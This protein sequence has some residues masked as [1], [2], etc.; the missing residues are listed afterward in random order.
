MVVMAR[1][2][3]SRRGKS[4]SSKPYVTEAPEWSNT[5][6]EE[7]TKLVVELGKSG[8][9]TAEIGTIL[10]DQHAVPNVK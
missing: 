3:K 9:T 10:R 1:M 6:V 5:D 7:V 8:H 4:G 2:Y